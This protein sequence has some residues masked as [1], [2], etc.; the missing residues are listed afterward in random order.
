MVL[1]SP[2]IALAFLIAKI[3]KNA[4]IQ[5]EFKVTTTCG[6]TL[7]TKSTKIDKNAKI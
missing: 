4:K 6:C 5:I 1:H 2:L 3:P 7:L